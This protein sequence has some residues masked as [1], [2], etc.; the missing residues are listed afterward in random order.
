MPATH[1]FKIVN[2]DING[3]IKLDYNNLKKTVLVIRSVDHKLR[4]QII[5][6]LTESPKL[7]VSEI[8][9]KLRI[10]QSIASQH[11]ALLRRSGVVQTK[12]SGKFIYYT[13]NQERL[14]EISELIK[15]LA[16]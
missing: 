16:K 10:E 7:T 11:L 13:L 15:E 5:K 14:I 1:A 4:Q 2:S 12:R 3:E 8:Y 6:M 9:L